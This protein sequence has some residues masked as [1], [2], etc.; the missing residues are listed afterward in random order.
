MTI[1]YLL[2][3]TYLAKQARKYTPLFEKHIFIGFVLNS[4]LSFP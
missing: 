3:V 4:K 1:F 2:A